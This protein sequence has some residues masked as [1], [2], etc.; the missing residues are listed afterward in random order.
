MK[1]WFVY[2]LFLVGINDV[3]YKCDV[4]LYL[5]FLES[6]FTLNPEGTRILWIQIL[7]NYTK[8]ENG[9]KA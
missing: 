8:G 7:I 9:R 1:N 4:K 3:V 2:G 6:K 5:L